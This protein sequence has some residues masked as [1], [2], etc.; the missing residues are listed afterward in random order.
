M[1]KPIY[2]EKGAPPKGPYS[3]AIVA[4]G[5]TVYV[6]AQGPIDPETGTLIEGT[7]EMKARQVL[8]NVSVI[9]EEAGTSWSQVVKVNL[10]LNDMSNFPALNTLYQEYVSE[11]FPA[12]TTAQSNIGDIALFID[13]IALVPSD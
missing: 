6:S 8:E 2:S 7:F 4:Q 11:P 12:R 3:Q 10:L 13:C 9:L 5:P 1:R